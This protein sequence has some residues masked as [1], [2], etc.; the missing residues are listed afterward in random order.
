LSFSGLALA[1]AIRSEIDLIFDVGFTTT[2]LRDRAIS[3]TAAK[4]LCGSNGSLLFRLGLTAWAKLASSSVYPSGSLVATAC[5]P[6]IVPAPGLFSMMTDLP[7]S[8]EISAGSEGDHDLDDLGGVFG[9]N[10]GG[11]QCRCQR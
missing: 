7:R 9:A 11:G 5:V 2:M 6:T 3:A 10:R 1:S 4:S 8:D